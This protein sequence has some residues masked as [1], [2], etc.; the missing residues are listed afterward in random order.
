MG[1]TKLLLLDSLLQESRAA[2]QDV[3]Q[4]SAAAGSGGAAEEGGEHQEDL[5]QPGRRGHQEVHPGQ[6]GEGLPDGGLLQGGREPLEGEVL[7]MLRALAQA[8]S[9]RYVAEQSGED[10]LLQGFHGKNTNPYREKS[11]CSVL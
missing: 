1:T 3:W 9:L 7:V 5:R 4:Y 8:P 10:L 2:G 11:S 6:R